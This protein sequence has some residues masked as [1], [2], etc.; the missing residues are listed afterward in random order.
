MSI[1]VKLKKEKSNAFCHIKRSVIP[2]VQYTS[3]YNP[4]NNVDKAIYKMNKTF[5]DYI[6]SNINNGSNKFYNKLYNLLKKVYFPKF[7]FIKRNN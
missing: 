5:P 4:D 1:E 2:I 7:D 3:K 6:N